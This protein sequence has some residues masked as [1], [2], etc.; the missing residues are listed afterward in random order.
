MWAQLICSVCVCVCV[1]AW[2]V[3][4]SSRY[5][6]FCLKYM[7][8]CLSKWWNASRGSSRKALFLFFTCPTRLWCSAR[9]RLDR[10]FSGSPVQAMIAVPIVRLLLGRRF[11]PVSPLY[12]GIPYISTESTLVTPYFKTSARLSRFQGEHNARPLSQWHQ[13]QIH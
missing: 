6:A 10:S 1:R 4:F 8:F 9:H 7:C 13:H 11:F 5:V 12:S 2:D 3:L